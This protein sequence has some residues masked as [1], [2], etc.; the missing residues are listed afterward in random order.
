[1]H[2]PLHGLFPLLKLLLR[3]RLDVHHTHRRVMVIQQGSIPREALKAKK[4]LG[5]KFAVRASVLGM[6]LMGDAT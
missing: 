2:V 4:L 3:A 5:V 1:M 6:S